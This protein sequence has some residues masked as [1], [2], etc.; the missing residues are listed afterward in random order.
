M[1]S[2]V[3]LPLSRLKLDKGLVLIKNLTLAES[4]QLKSQTEAMSL[5]ELVDYVFKAL[6]VL[7]LKLI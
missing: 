7:Q 3:L 5:K 1:E 6:E 2:I 4:S